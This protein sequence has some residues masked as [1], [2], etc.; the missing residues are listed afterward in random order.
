MKTIVKYMVGVA[1]CVFTMTSCSEFTPEGYDV[2]P[3]LPTVQNLQATA[4]GHNIDVTWQLPAASNITDVLFI[5]DGKKTEPIS[6][7]PSA[8]SYTVVGQQL[9]VEGLYTVKVCY[10]DKYVSEGVST[11]YTL[12]EENLPGV[13]DLKL[14]TSGRKVT[15]TWSAPDASGVTGY[16]I[17]TN[18]DVAS[19]VSYP[20]ETTSAT[21]KA[22]PMDVDLAYDVQAMYDTYYPSVSSIVTTKI[23]LIISKIGYVMT[24]PTIADL[25]DDDEQAAAQWFIQ[26]ENCELVQAADLASIDPDN[27]SVL[28]ILIDRQGLEM[29]WQNLPSEITSASAIEALKNYSAEG[30]NLYLSNMATQLTVPL[31]FV[32]DNMA[33]TVFSSGTGGTGGDVWTINP[34]LGW[35]FRPGSGTNV[36]GQ[37]PF[38]DRT[39]HAI[40]KG[41]TLEDPNGYGYPNLPLI[42]PGQREDHNCLWDCNIYGKGD[43]ADVIANFESITGSLVLATWGH[44]RDHCVA[45]LVDFFATPVHGRCVAN[46]FAAYEWNQNSGPNPYQANVEKLTE[47]ILNYL[48]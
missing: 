18:G 40:F 27:Y 20:A 25:P 34:N 33:P 36:E 29:G 24:A 43:S 7:G 8:T 5:L 4:T 6:L 13:K 3:D 1:A 31:G 39:E 14:S 37:Q 38:Y 22:Q 12:P 41:L 11:T 28:W 21:L 47:N 10:D 35:D 23:P 17:V 19:A 30:G 32:P 44:V 9:M 42:G 15:L 26:Q 45:G 2:I 16:R 48:K 46:G